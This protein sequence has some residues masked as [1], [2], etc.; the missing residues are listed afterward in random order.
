MSGLTAYGGMA[1]KIRAKQKKMLQH[2][3]YMLLLSCKSVQEVLHI[4]SESEGY[5]DVFNE[6]DINLLH[7]GTVELKLKES[8][9]NEYIGLFKYSNEEQRKFLKMH[10]RKMELSFLKG[11]LRK[12]FSKE[13]T[14]ITV[15][16]EVQHLFIKNS[17]LNI[18]LLAEAR[19]IEELIDALIGSEYYSCLKSVYQQRADTIFE[20]EA[21]LDMFYFTKLWKV[22]AT[23]FSGLDLEILTESYGYKI[24][25]LNLQWIYRCKK[26]YRVSNTEIYAMLIPVTYKLHKI[27]LTAIVEAPDIEEYDKLIKKTGYGKMYPDISGDKLEDIY[28]DL[29]DRVNEVGFRKYPYSV[30]ILNTY[31]YKKEYEINK[32][33]TILECIRYGIDHERILQYSGLKGGMDL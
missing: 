28:I 13:K 22:I 17:K 4:L 15:S 23:D 5:Q 29:L 26:Y 18:D 8:F 2:T 6:N 16:A 20:Y 32:I 21:S 1:T 14:S 24:D 33:T 9:Y 31:L 10:F 27:E 30:A 12:M 19:T 25:I 7:R 3:E 11:C